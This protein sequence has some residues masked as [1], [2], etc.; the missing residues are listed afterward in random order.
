MDRADT[1]RMKTLS[2]L[3]FMRV[4]TEE[5]EF[6]GHV[7][8]FRSPGAKEEVSAKQIDAGRAIGDLIYGRKGLLERLGFREPGVQTIPWTAVVKM[9]DDR[10][11]VAVKKSAARRRHKR[12]R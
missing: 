8:D 7:F 6:L 11:I 4:V 12:G 2:Q 5:G 1:G 3:K 9:H 10:L